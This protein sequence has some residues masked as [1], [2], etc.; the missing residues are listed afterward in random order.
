MAIDLFPSLA[1]LGKKRDL[2]WYTKLSN[3]DKK[4]AAPFVIA[5]WLTGTSDA[6][7]IVRINTFVNPYLFSMGEDKD[8]LFRLLA[9]ASTG[10]TGRY[11]WIKGPTSAGS[12]SLIVKVIADYYDIT[13][14]EAKSYIPQIS[15]DIIT[16]MA[17]ELG[18]E[19]E[20]LAKLK[21]EFG[22]GSRNPEKD[23]TK[24]KG[25]GRA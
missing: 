19:K 14:R 12:S 8:L 10:S 4:S 6:A 23:G 3:E 5:R 1:T 9:S 2:E 17:E 21:K 22:N 11:Q 18:W 7:Q 20:D 13:S 15:H 16:E 25:R 24:P